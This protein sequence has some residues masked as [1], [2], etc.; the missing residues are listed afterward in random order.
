M[1]T[2]ILVNGQV[3]EIRV[4]NG[5]CCHPNPPTIDIPSPPNI[6]R[7][8]IRVSRVLV[9]QYVTSGVQYVLESSFDLFTWSPT[10]PEFTAVSEILESEFDVNVTG[11]FFRLREI[12]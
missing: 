2:A 12:P 11:R 3:V 5:G 9:T 1:A 7:L 4:T 6:P 8:G 10:G